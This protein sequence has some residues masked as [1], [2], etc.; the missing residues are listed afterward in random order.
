MPVFRSSGVR[1]REE[2][3]EE[4]DSKWFAERD[5]RVSKN[6]GGG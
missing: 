6:L 1:G 5:R 4:D 3:V 2:A